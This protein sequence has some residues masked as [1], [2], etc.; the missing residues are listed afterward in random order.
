MTV[1]TA[2][3]P[4]TSG[5]QWFMLAMLTFV[6][7]VNFLDRQLLAILAPWIKE[8]LHVTDQQLGLIGG[9]YF[10][11]FYCFIAIPVGWFADRTNRVGVLAL[12]CAIWSGAT[13][14]C[15]LAANYGQLVA[16]RMTVGFGEAGGVPPSY[17]II[18]DSF[19]PGRRGVAFGIYNFGPP[20]GAALGVAF[21]GWIA[22]HFGWQRAFLTIGGIGIVTAV[23]V[24]LLLRDPPRGGLDGAAGSAPVTYE[25]APFWATTRMF[26][27]H[28]IL[29]LAG[30][31]G[32]A[33]QFVTYG[34]GNFAPLFLKEAVLTGGKGM[35]ADQ[36]TI[37][38][39]LALLIGMGGGIV[40]SGRVLDAVTKRSRA[41][42]ATAPAI[43]LAIAMP[44]YL[45][46]VWAPAWPLALSLLVVVMLFNYVY[47]SAT[48]ALVQ[49]VVPA[50]QRVLCGAL[51][52]LV[53]NFIGLGLGPTFVGW[54]STTL[55]GEG[56]ANGRQIAL[57]SL[58]PFYFVAIFLFLW[59][60]R[61]LRA[62]RKVAA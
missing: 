57:Y 32:G 54:L 43:A 45:A 30:L 12:A 62:E 50:N 38:Y 16:A 36:I 11:C 7:M 9:F 21:G 27:T 41:G 35:S 26:F 2:E 47:L 4:A 6:Y 20:A 49:D 5:R 58:T 23:L 15:G 8:A 31:A 37:W 28:P 51:L 42:Y 33:T 34:L 48:V 52:L 14:A 10:A 53:M 29:L 13:A 19:P 22:I 24:L 44:F 56:I 60:A 59:L 40:I 17:A 1:A 46:F 55:T 25:K 61:Y 18:T 3:H 39:A